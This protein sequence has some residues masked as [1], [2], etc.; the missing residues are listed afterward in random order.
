MLVQ[1]LV[2]LVSER[3]AEAVNWATLA[4]LLLVP[5]SFL[6]GLL[7]SRFGATT[8]RLVAE[9]SEKRTPEEVQDVLR[10]AL[11]DPTLELGYL[12]ADTP[13]YVDVSG[14]PLKLPQADD[15]PHRH[16]RRRRA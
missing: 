8:R 11:R 16:A 2:A 12:S 14:R 5:L 13:G 1:N 4:A 15:G 9:L 3:A 6:Y 7:R 10:R